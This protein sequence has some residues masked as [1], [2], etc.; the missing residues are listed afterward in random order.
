MDR[1]IG[2]TAKTQVRYPVDLS[3]III[4]NG[5][6]TPTLG[7]GDPN[8][9]YI[10]GLTRTGTGVYTFTTRDPFVAL[11]NSDASVTL[12][13]PAGQWNAMLG[14]VKNA[15]GAFTFTVSIFNGAAAA[16]IAANAAS[17][18]SVWLRFRNSNLVP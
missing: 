15:N 9:T 6:G 1:M 5:A 2:I 12:A 7:E 3:F 8:A 11:N 16:D 10:V 18:I 4:P 17:Y 13:A 14:A